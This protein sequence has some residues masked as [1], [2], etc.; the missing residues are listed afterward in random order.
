MDKICPISSI[1]TKSGGLSIGIL[2][3]VF[4][5]ETGAINLTLS[6]ISNFIIEIKYNLDQY[7]H[8]V[9]ENI[10]EIAILSLESVIIEIN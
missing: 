8:K 5:Y 7:K 4:K 2:S 6:L 1:A 10:N 3:D 9:K